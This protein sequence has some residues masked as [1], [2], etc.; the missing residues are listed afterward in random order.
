MPRPNLVFLSFE[1]KLIYIPSV[2]SLTDALTDS[3]ICPDNALRNLA[4]VE[5]N[6]LWPNSYK[7]SDSKSPG[8][9]SLEAATTL[10][11]ST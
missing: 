6:T 3:L 7:V 9:R 4:K 2:Y 10:I 5:K 11:L 8:Q 1:Q